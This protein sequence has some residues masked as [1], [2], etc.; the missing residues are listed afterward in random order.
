MEMD[1]RKRLYFWFLTFENYKDNLTT[2]KKKNRLMYI[3]YYLAEN[4]LFILLS[5]VYYFIKLITLIYQ[6]KI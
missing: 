1:F 5:I 4:L 6:V 2:Y 3:P